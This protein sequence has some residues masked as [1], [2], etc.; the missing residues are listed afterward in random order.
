MY[1]SK[2]CQPAKHS[3]ETFMLYKL[4]VTLSLFSKR[5][6]NYSGLN[7]RAFYF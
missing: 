2:M 4:N 6:K 1:K 5:L 7:V 3:E